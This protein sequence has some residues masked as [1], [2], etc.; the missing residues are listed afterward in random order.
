MT[1]TETSMKAIYDQFKD[2]D[3]INACKTG[4]ISEAMD[5]IFLNEKIDFHKDVNNIFINACYLGFLDLAKWIYGLRLSVNLDLSYTGDCPFRFACQNGHLEMAKWLYSVNKNL[6]ISNS[7][8]YAFRFACYDGHLEVVK[9]LYS[10]KKD[11]DISIWK[12]NTFRTVCSSGKLDVAKYLIDIKPD[13]DISY[14]NE[15]AFRQVCE[16]GHL[17]VAKW[18]LSIKENI[19][20]TA[21]NDDAFKKACANEHGDSSVALWLKELRPDRYEVVV[22]EA[23]K[24]T[25]SYVLVEFHYIGKVKCSVEECPICIVKECKIQTKC[26]HSFCKRCLEVWLTT[27]TTCPCCREH[28]C[29]NELYEITATI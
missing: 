9:W 24:I 6:N 3:F 28:V 29:C 14:N 1:E 20:I 11:I 19:D 8:D 18:L 7:N 2:K 12:D 5:M 10:I 27:H 26:K 25:L 21:E 17:E 15:L 16:A 23:N 13:I 4:K 22:N